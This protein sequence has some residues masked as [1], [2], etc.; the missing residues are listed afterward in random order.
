[1]I[2]ACRGSVRC[3]ST[4]TRRCARPFRVNAC[5]LNCK[6]PHVCIVC[7]GLRKDL[8][9][10]HVYVRKPRVGSSSMTSAHRRTSRYCSPTNPRACSNTVQIHRIQIVL[11]TTT[12]RCAWSTYLI[13]M[14]RKRDG[15]RYIMACAEASAVLRLLRGPGIGGVF[16]DA[17]W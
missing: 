1:M 7:H 2:G 12:P 15:A 17:K 16:K 10:T 6:Y 4:K 8:V 14:S 5:Q 9:H 11:R 3:F 13:C